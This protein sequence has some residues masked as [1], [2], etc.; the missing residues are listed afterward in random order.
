MTSIF[1]MTAINLTLVSYV[2]SIKR[3]SVIMSVLFGYFIFKE[4]GL[5]ERLT[6]TSIM[7]IGVLSIAL[8]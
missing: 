1:Q 7:V 5:K 4:K 6:G 2:I 8:S 3:T